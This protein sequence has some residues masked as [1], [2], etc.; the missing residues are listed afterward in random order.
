MTRLQ[1]LQVAIKRVWT[2]CQT[3][4]AARR[5]RLI[6]RPLPI[7]LEDAADR[8]R[9]VLARIRELVEDPVLSH[10]LHHEIETATELWRQTSA[11]D[12]H[13]REQYYWRARAAIKLAETLEHRMKDEIWRLE[14]V[15]AQENTIWQ[16]KAM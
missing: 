1:S 12:Q 8:K 15:K 3:W 11:Q 16:M 7:G 13:L 6:A 9:R 10:V 14:K 4:L 5:I 2:D